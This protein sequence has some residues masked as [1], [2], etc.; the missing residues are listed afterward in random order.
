MALKAQLLP[1]AGERWHPRGRG[2]RENSGFALEQDPP[3]LSHLLQAGEPQAGAGRQAGKPQDLPFKHPTHFLTPLL[4]AEGPSGAQAP[5]LRVSHNSPGL[6]RFGADP[7]PFSHLYF[8][9]IPKLF[10]PLQLKPPFAS[11]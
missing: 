5:P 9:A 8:T 4:E 11:L 6:T 10:F 3:A 7:P 2:E 1:S